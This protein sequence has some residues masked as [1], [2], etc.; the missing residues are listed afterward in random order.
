MARMYSQDEQAECTAKMNVLQWA[1]CRVGVTV[2]PGS[3]GQRILMQMNRSP[4]GLLMMTGCML[5]RILVGQKPLPLTPWRVTVLGMAL[6]TVLSQQ[7]C[8][9]C[10]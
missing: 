8:K 9:S 1:G 10:N 4:M 7:V 6:G 3:A 5:S 2:W